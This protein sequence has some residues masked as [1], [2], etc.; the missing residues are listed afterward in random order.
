MAILKGFPPSNTIS[1]SV[2][3]TE[4]DL[5][6]IA[7]EQSFH[8]A[9][10]VGFA[11]K[12]P[13]N[14]PTV[15]RSRR[16]LNTVFGYPHPEQGDP[17]L[18]YAAEQYL[19]VANELYVVRVA[20]TDPVSWERAKTAQV[21]V[22]SAGG[23]VV[24]VSSTA[25]P[26]SLSKDMY[27]RWRLNGVLSSKTLV[28]LSDANH[29]DPAVQSGGYSASQLA[30]DLN[31]QIDPSIDGIEFF[32]TLE[33]TN[34]VEAE[35]KTTSDTDSSA[36][37]NLDNDDLVAGSITG[38]VV[39]AGTVVQ[40]FTVNSEGGFSFRQIATSSVKA[41]SGSV[42]L[43]AGT[44][45]LN[46][47][48]S[49]SAGVNGVYVDYKYTETFST[50]RIGVRTTFSFGPRASLE[51]VSVADSLYGPTSADVGSNVHV[52]PTGLGS[53]M[54]VAQFT[55][56]VAADFDF[57]TLSE[58]DLQ[59]VVDGTDNVL[60]DNV[61]QV[62]DLSDLGGDEDASA[63]DVVSAINA[64]IADGDVPGGFEAV[65]VGNFVSLRTLH[66]G[67]DSRLL[68]KSES[69]VFELLGFDAPLVDPT[70]SASDAGDYV[71]AE[72]SS[73]EGVSGDESVSTYGLVR[74]DS[75]RYGDVSVTL[76]ADS[77]GIDGNSTQVVIKNN[78]REGNFIM[79]VYNNGVQVESWGNLSKDETSRYYVET[80][81][82]LVSDFVRA[83]DNSANPS[84]PMDGTYSLAGGG[85]GIPADPDDQDYFLIG[86]AVGSTGLYAL[87]EPEQIDLD[88]VA[89]PGHSS[90][91]VV[92][93]LIDMVQN[94]R[95]DAMA[96]VDAPFGLT[97]KEIVAWQNGSHPLNTTRFDSDFAALYW[98][99]VKIR[100]SF[101][102][103]DVWVPPSGSIM[104]VYARN[105]ALAAPWFAPAGVNRGVVSGITDVFSRPTLEER[106]LMYGNR[107]AINPI[108]Q[109][110]D[111]QD[112]VVWGQKTLQRRPTA[113]DR[114]NVRR[115]MF[116][117]EKRIRQ[118]SRALLFEPHDEQFRSRFVDIATRILQEVRVGRG[119]T[120]F[121][122][123]ADEELNTPD[124][125][126]RNEFRARIGVQPTKAVEFMFI[127]FSI[128][129]TGSFE[130]GSDTF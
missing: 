37:F 105:D 49:L 121:I 112:Y 18:I 106:D 83:T 104:A 60:V 13:I 59:V 122:I 111:F 82:S 15:I 70:D 42:D 93:A 16:Q 50:T 86:N 69:S 90:T 128:H 87:S 48:G 29:P 9:G 2:R 107:N 45:T 89:V 1:P 40:S 44:L 92:L 6:F 55:G 88:L 119:L 21:E 31:L 12:G 125:I 102:N 81:L 25:G 100:D 14:I 58:F 108:V 22:P 61:N 77:A 91:A 27:F 80:F 79:E 101:N 109:Y 118:A 76:T 28:A 33:Q 127:E 85:D 36:T 75:N 46:Y 116:V 39:V 73:P 95:M 97:V 84:P 123:K 74:G 130:A 96:I 72:G 110:A 23:E 53:G 52:S 129:R 3:I 43:G 5:S 98:P 114:V 51:L 32:S 124:V 24:F 38:R 11:S 113:L 78:I 65:A 10:L 34:F 19:L 103:I 41:V 67:T 4:K 20:D 94:M 47:N 7:P 68:V 35:N 99:W 56:S 120:D 8:R 17:Y 64:A 71:T 126:D 66:A 30:E 54:A 26:Y 117:I 115:L 62:I 63:A 57:T